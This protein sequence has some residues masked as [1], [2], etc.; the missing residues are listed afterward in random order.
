LIKI[1]ACNCCWPCFLVPWWSIDMLIY[2]N[3]SRNPDFCVDLFSCPGSSY[4]L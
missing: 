3:F 2:H 1:E 4:R